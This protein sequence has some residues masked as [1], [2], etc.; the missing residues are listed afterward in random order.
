V[1]KIT[2]N[3]IVD[4]T[5]GVELNIKEYRSEKQ[6]VKKQKEK[7]KTELLKLLQC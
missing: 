5:E 3:A 7:S 2:L 6:W 1:S 4:G